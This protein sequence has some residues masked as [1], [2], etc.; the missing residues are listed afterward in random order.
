MRHLLL[1]PLLT[2][3]A[4]T[5]WGQ[6]VMSL[7][8]RALDAS[9]RTPLLVG[10]VD[11]LSFMGSGQAVAHFTDLSGEDIAVPLS[12][13]QID[14]IDFATAPTDEEKG[15]DHYQ[16]FALYIDTRDRQPVADR[17][18]WLTCHISLDGKEQYSDLSTTARIRGRGNSTW[19]WYDKKP[20][21]I[22]LDSKSKLL[23]LSKA[24]NWNLLAN[25][26][27]PADLMNT[28][29]F[30]A[31][32]FLGM[33]HTNHTR[34]VELF[35]NG[36]YVG[37]YQLTEKIEVADNRIDI[38]RDSGVLLSLDLDD[39]PSLSPSAG[40]N[41]WSQVYGLPVCVKYPEDASSA[42]LAEIKAD[43]AQLERAIQRRDYEAADSL[44][45]MSTFISILQ[46]HEYLYNVE[47]DAPRSLYLY[48][49]AGGKYTFGPV[50]DWDAGYDFD[51]ADMY[52]GHTFFTDYTEL[53][54]GTDPVNYTGAAYHVSGF[55]TSLFGEAHFVKRY[56][57][58]WQAVS[59]SLYTV[60]WAECQAYASYLDDGAYTRDASRWPIS[61]TWPLDAKH[62]MSL[63]LKNRLTYLTNVIAA[64]PDGE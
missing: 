21:K 13:E 20:Y 11:S 62:K 31:A 8:M 47:I 33:P 37:L 52:T 4:L 34:Y 56:K 15:H 50:W 45:D 18:T 35:L 10:E 55:F 46:L 17:D 3:V 63:W 58:A 2:S 1:V 27:D 57:E 64:Y 41:F 5:S 51:W 7:H 16:T 59:D 19:E 53:I 24:K 22:K 44:M 49:D 61:G 14:S 28:F 23:G 42:R 40:D 26:R 38:D 29:A 9:W 43:F 60:P 36:D 54:F 6:D 30:E 39:G 48:R 25:Y 32:R 12:L